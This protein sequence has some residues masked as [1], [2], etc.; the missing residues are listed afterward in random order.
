MHAHWNFSPE[1]DPHRMSLKPKHLEIDTPAHTNTRTN[2][3]VNMFIQP[4]SFGEMCTVSVD[5]SF[6]V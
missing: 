3:N 5:E 4:G 6:H 2:H 1:C